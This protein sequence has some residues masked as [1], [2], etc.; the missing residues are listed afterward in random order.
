MHLLHSLVF[1]RDSAQGCFPHFSVTIPLY[2][3]TIYVSIYACIYIF[4]VVH[5][6]HTHLTSLYTQHTLLTS[7]CTQY[8]H[9][10]DTSAATWHCA[11]GSFTVMV[12][13]FHTYTH[14]YKHTCIHTKHTR[15]HTKH[16]RIHTKHT[17]IHT[18]IYIHTYILQ[19]NVQETSAPG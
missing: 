17:R 6:I 19:F 4:T 3:P 12:G 9:L 13:S 1:W 11:W 18:H 7:S 5:T 2:T 10:H 14:T 8:T 16:T 15:I